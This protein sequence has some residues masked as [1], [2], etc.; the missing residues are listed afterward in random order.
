MAHTSNPSTLGG[1][2]DH[3]VRR[4]RPSWLTQWN[5]SLLKIQKM[6]QAWWRAPVVPATQDA[7]AGKWHEPGRR[8][9]QWGEIGH[10]TP[11][12]ATE[13][14]SISKIIIIII[15]I[16]IV[17]VIVKFISLHYKHSSCSLICPVI[18][19]VH[20]LNESSAECR[21]NISSVKMLW[22]NQLGYILMA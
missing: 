11:A 13:R 21:I 1:W 5:P 2:E 6:S 9:L 14:D 16:I 19:K 22:I 7:E 10:C 8:S 12:W 4:S 17:I 18:E 15:I 20:S 3:K